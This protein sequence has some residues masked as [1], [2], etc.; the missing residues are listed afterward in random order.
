M[1]KFKYCI[2]ILGF[3]LAIN[4]TTLKIF[5]Y[6]IIYNISPSMSQGFYLLYNFKTMKRYEIVAA[7]INNNQSQQLINHYKLHEAGV[8]RNG[9]AVLKYVIALS[10]DIVSIDHQGI[11]V[12]GKIIKNS[13]A[14]VRSNIN[15]H[16]YQ[17]RSDE[18]LLFAD[19]VADSIDSRYFGI[20][21]DAQ[22]RAKVIKI[23]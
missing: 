16:N 4:L 17:L 10:P 15:L 11:V 8:C 6:G 5:N 3:L 19:K 18:Y 9:L 2:I 1:F 20:V 22:I 12:N 13:A 14:I 7:C 23:N 21:H